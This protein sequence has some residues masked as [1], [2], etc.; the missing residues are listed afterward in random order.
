MLYEFRDAFVAWSSSFGQPVVMMNN[1]KMRP[2]KEGAC[3]TMISNKSFKRKII[4]L[5]M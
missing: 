4:T 2:Q 5:K 3:C 1:E